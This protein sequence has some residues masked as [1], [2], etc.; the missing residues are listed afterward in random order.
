MNAKK[1]QIVGCG[2]LVWVSISLGIIG[3]SQSRNLYI[4]LWSP[5]KSSFA[6]LIGGKYT[7]VEKVSVSGTAI[8]VPLDQYQERFPDNDHTIIV[9]KN[10]DVYYLTKTNKETYVSKKERYWSI[11]D[12]MLLTRKVTGIDSGLGIAVIFQGRKWAGV[13]AMNLSLFIVLVIIIPDR[14]AQRIRG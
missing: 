7:F 4:E 2:F 14:I 11:L 8:F 13:I 12:A 1:K 6:N 10:G 5:E 9:Q 3:F